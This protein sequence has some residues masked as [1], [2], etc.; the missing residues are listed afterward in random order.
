MIRS[1]IAKRIAI[2][3]PA[4][5]GIAEG[6][7]ICVMRSDDQQP[8]MRYGD[9]V[10]LF[11]SPDHIRNVLDHM[12]GPY[13][14]EAIATEWI[15]ETIQV[16]DHIRLRSGIAINP[17]RTRIFLDSTA[18]VENPHH[19]KITTQSSRDSITY[20]KVLMPAYN[21][22]AILKPESCNVVCPEDA[23]ATHR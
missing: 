21:P 4:M 13:G 10:E 12:D 5:G 22:P 8:A 1:E 20:A 16:A 2:E 6:T 19:D 15:R 3:M 9:A 18:N 23:R 14:I 11:H 7:K 17:D